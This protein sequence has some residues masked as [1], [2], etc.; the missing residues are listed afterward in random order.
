MSLGTLFSLISRLRAP[1]PA[2]VLLDTGDADLV[3]ARVTSQSRQDAHDIEIVDWRG[4][5]LLLPSIARLHKLATLEKALAV[6]TLGRLQSADH[7]S[8]AKALTEIFAEWRK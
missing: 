5:G 7:Q 6:R 2:L 1:P 3:V 4:A 8:V